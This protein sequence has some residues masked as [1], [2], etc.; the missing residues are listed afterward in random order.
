[1][2]TLAGEPPT[3][4]RRGMNA[5]QLSSPAVATHYADAVAINSTMLPMLQL[6]KRLCAKQ[7]AS[8]LSVSTSHDVLVLGTGDS[9]TV[10]YW[11]HRT[12]FQ[13]RYCNLRGKHET[14]RCEA[15]EVERLVDSLVT[16]L[17]LSRDYS[18]P[19]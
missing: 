18:K 9:I 8:D 1:M 4:Q 13:V 14:H 12:L 19:A 6:V 10:E 16:R 15:S 7:Y 2:E 11:P 5:Q 3:R 17:H